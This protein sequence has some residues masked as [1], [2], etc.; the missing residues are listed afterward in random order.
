MIRTKKQTP[1]SGRQDICAQMKPHP[2]SGTVAGDTSV[3]VK[4]NCGIK[5]CWIITL[6]RQ[7]A[8][9]VLSKTGYMGGFH[10]GGNKQ[11]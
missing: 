7:N 8:K 1:A 11:S 3:C 6:E 2:Q 10:N 5:P 4:W 9:A